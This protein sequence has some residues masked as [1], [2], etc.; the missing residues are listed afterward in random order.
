VVTIHNLDSG[1]R[2]PKGYIDES[3]DEHD[4]QHS[5]LSIA[6]YV[7]SPESWSQFETRWFRYG[8]RVATQRNPSGQARQQQAGGE[9]LATLGL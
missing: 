9:G 3:R 4:P 5:A 1:T 2:L 6:G 7:G 8:D